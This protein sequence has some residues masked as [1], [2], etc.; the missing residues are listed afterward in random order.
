VA[1]A[2]R[3]GV[4]LIALED[5]AQRWESPVEVGVRPVQLLSHAGHLVLASD[6]TLTVF[7]EDGR[8]IGTLT[9]P[10]ERTSSVLQLAGGDRIATTLGDGSLALLRLVEDGDT[11]R[12]LQVTEHPHGDAEARLAATAGGVVAAFDNGSVSAFAVTGDAVTKRW[13]VEGAAGPEVVTLVARA[14][15]VL[16]GNGDGRNVVLDAAS[17]ETRTA[18]DH[19]RRVLAAELAAERLLVYDES[20]AAAAYRQR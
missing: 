7:E 1:T 13:T 18:V 5:G 15:R 6:R 10:A 11:M 17:G 12:M 8:Q 4:R 3:D 2:T 19:D 14:G 16:V 9:L 20:G